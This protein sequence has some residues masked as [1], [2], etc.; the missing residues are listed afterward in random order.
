MAIDFPNSPTTGQVFSVGTKSWVYNGSVWT[1]N[2]SAGASN[3]NIGGMVLI[4]KQTFSGV[5][6]ISLDNVFS[7]AYSNYL[8]VITGTGSVNNNPAIRMRTGGVTDSGANYDFQYVSANA[9]S[10]TGGRSTAQ[11]SATLAD[12]N[13]TLSGM[14]VTVYNPF[15]STIT[16]WQATA[17]SPTSGSLLQSYIGR[18]ATAASQDG[19]TLLVSTGTFSG[20]I[21]VYGYSETVGDAASVSVTPG[22]VYI[23]SQAFSA[24]S[25]VSVNGCFTSLYDEYQI[26]L[27]PF[28]VGANDI[29]IF[30]RMRAAG[31]D[32][33]GA[34]YF[35]QLHFAYGTAFGASGAASQTAFNLADTTS[36]AYLILNVARPFLT[37]KTALMGTRYAYQN[38]VT[39]M[40][41][42][43]A[44]GLYDATTSFDG[45][46]IY[47][48]SS[49][50]TGTLKVYGVKR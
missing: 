39:T 15:A 2:A 46:T 30:M 13:T 45:F 17:F 28:T 9:T 1:S 27:S 22:L 32:A 37:A 40:V 31:A 33:T 23:T 12:W 34:S 41:F 36:E 5:T 24:A 50:I 25:S 10:V 8:L 19:F 3:A 4:R 38:N 48:A 21:L 49:T 42:A 26:V 44:A 43:N 7:S 35:T 6:S 47:P 18:H 11:T 14:N 20:T 16:G 29:T